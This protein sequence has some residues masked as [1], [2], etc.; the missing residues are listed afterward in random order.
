VFR[1]RAMAFF[2]SDIELHIFGFISP[3]NFLKLEP[4]IM[5]ACT[6]HIKGFLYRGFFET[7]I[8]MIPILQI[9]GNLPRGRLVPL[10]WE[11]VMVISNLDL[12][13]LFPTPSPIS[14]HYVINDLFRRVHYIY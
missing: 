14:P 9:I 3:V 7:P 8:L 5:A 12:I 2:T 10:E 6:A 1:A 11:N 13:A 4:S